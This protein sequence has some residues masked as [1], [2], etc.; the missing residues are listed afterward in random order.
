MTLEITEENSLNKISIRRTD[1][2]VKVRPNAE[3]RHDPFNSDY[4]GSNGLKFINETNH[5]W[6]S[7][8]YRKARADKMSPSKRRMVL[9]MF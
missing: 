1:D 2:N 9:V 5:E 7:L 6:L 3:I 4:T 8:N